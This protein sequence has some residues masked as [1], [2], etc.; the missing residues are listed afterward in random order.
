M[1]MGDLIRRKAALEALNG[2]HRI[3]TICGGVFDCYVSDLLE[4]R[5]MEQ[6]VK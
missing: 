4:Y 5:R 2:N 6:E 3:R 1:M